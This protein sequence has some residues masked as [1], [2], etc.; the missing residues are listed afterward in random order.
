MAAALRGRL[1]GASLSVTPRHVGPLCCCG[2]FLERTERAPPPALP[3]GPCALNTDLSLRPLRDGATDRQPADVRPGIRVFT[4][5][6]GVSCAL[7]LQTWASFWRPPLRTPRP[8]GGPKSSSGEPPGSPPS[9]RLTF[10][11]FTSAFG[12][13]HRLAC[14]GGAWESRCECPCPRN[15]G[16]L[17]RGSGEFW[18]VLVSSLACRLREQRPPGTTK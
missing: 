15:T 2:S 4:G 1:P 13:G 3:P 8:P 14:R 18:R 6:R 12:V 5:R 7:E 17:L 11:S 16:G 9:V 10:L